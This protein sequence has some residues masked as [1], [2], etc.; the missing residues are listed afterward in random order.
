[1]YDVVNTSGELFERVQLPADRVVAGFGR[2]GVVYLARYD[3]AGKFWT[4]ERA[5]VI[6]R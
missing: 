6:R 3:R 1:M 2:G 4:L 5:T